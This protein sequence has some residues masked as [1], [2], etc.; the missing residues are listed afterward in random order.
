MR[1][2]L[3]V[4]VVAHGLEVGVAGVAA[5]LGGDDLAAPLGD[6]L[7]LGRVAERAGHGA[8]RRRSGSQPDQ[9]VE[10]RQLD[11][12]ALGGQQIR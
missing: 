4:E 7:D 3:L 5:P 11:R 6:A 1:G 10:L 9:S 2:G 8:Q 12:D